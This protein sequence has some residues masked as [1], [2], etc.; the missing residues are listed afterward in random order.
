VVAVI[1][2]YHSDCAKIELPILAA[3]AHGPIGVVSPSNTYVG[4]THGGPGAAPGDPAR[5][6]PTGRRSYARVVAPDDVQGAADALLAHDLRA[7][8]V[9]V[10]S[11]GTPYGRGIA[12]AFTRAARRL[13]VGAAGTARWDRTPPHALRPRHADAVFLAGYPAS[14]G[15]DAVIALRRRLPAHAPVIVPDGFFDAGNLAHIGQAGEGMLISIAGPPLDALGERGQRFTSRLAT[16]IGTRPYT[17]SIYAAQAA[18]LLLD[19]IGRSD[20]TRASVVENVL[21]ARIDGGILGTFAIT[22]TGDT[23]SRVVSV[24]R[25]THGRPSLWRTLEPPAS[26]V[27]DSRG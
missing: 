19:A 10:V 3:A 21:S 1:G 22:P 7:R 13:G 27:R 14:G 5:Y 26:L 23:T 12:A 25:V 20:G 11:D 24:Y 6:A 2:P 16:A 17:Y 8:H 4:L 9:F 18:E 15:G